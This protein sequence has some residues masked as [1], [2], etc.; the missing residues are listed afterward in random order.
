MGL[1]KKNFDL[2]NN[3]ISTFLHNKNDKSCLELGCQ[4]FVGIFNNGHIR[5]IMSNEFK[6]YTT[7]DLHNVEG[8]TKCDLSIY[9]ENLFNVDLITNFGTTEHVEYEDGQYN[10]W[11]NI[12]NWLNTDGISIHLTPE[13]GSWKGHSRYYTNFDFYKNLEKF[14]YKILELQQSTDENGNLNWCVIQKK[15]NLNFM[16]FDEFFKFMITDYSVTFDIID[17]INNPK[18]LK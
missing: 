9:Q 10:C 14:G 1:T 15:E 11:K 12:H 4:E 5:N 3:A 13:I 16:S 6:K 7:I 17:P 2:L 8:V 18:K